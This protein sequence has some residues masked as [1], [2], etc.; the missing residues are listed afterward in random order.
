M[1]ALRTTLSQRL[2]RLIAMA[3]AMVLLTFGMVIV[4]SATSARADTDPPAGTPATVSDDALPTWQ[5]NGVVW[6][7]VTI[8]NTVYVAGE[9]SQARPPGVAVGGPGSVNVGNLIAYDITTGNLITSFNHTLN[10][11]A[12]VITKSPDNSRIYVGGDFTTVD[13]QPRGHIAAFDVAS[14]AL[15]PSFSPNLS[16]EVKA[17]TVSSSA[18]YAGGAFDYDDGVYRHHL[19]AMSITNG[20]RLPWAPVTDNY[21]PWT[22][23]MTPDQSKVVIG[24]QFVTLNGQ[25]VDGLAAVDPVTGSLVPWAASTKIPDAVHGAIMGLSTDGTNIYG[26]GYA[27]GSG[28]SFEGEFSLN[29]AD[30]SINW[31]NDCQGDTYNTFPMNGALYTVSHV[32]NCEMIGG[33]TQLSDWS[34]NQKHALAFSTTSSGNY[35]QGPD[36]YGWNYSAYQYAK[37]LTWYPNFLFGSYTAQKQSGWSITGNGNYLSIGGEFPSVNGKAQYGLVRFAVRSKAPNKMGPTAC[38][39]A[40]TPSALAM[41]GGSAR[42]SW[43][44]ATDPDNA[45]LTYN[46]YR[47]GTAAPIYTTTQSNQYWNCPQMG[48]RDTGLVGGKAYT[49]KITAS[50]SLGNTYTLPTTNSVTA[51]SGSPS[52]Y[53]QDVAKDGASDFWTLGEPSGSTIYDSAGFND[54]TAQS[55]VT[56]GA[57]GP[58]S[59]DST[60]ASTFGGS[61]N[62]FAATNST[63]ATTPALSV[64]AWIKTTTTSGGKI[65]GYGDSNTGTSGSYDRHVYMDNAGHIIW[66][67]YPGSVQTIQSKNTYNDGAWHYIVASMDPTAGIALYVDGKKVAANAGV[68]SAQSYSGY[69]KI[70]G[71]NLSGWTNQP[72]SNYFAGTIG[73]VAIYPAALSLAQVQTHYTDGGGSLPTPTI[74][75]DAYG[76]AVYNSNPALYWRL[77][78]TAGSTAADASANG[79]TGVYSGGVTLGQPGAL[80]SQGTAATF[81]GTDGTIG[82]SDPVSNPTVYSE[83]LWFNTT[84]TAGGKLIGFGDQQ[85]GNSGNYD[86]HVYM[87]PDGRL[88]FG[89]YPGSASIITSPNSYNDGAWHHMVAT[90][91]PDGMNLY[92][93]GQDVA[94]GPQTQAQPYTGYWRV[95]GDSSWAGNNYFAGT[96]DEVAVYS[97]ELSASTVQAHYVAGGGVVPNQPPVAAFTSSVNNLNASFDGSGSSDPDGT[98]ASYSW[99]FG[100]NSTAGTG[101]NPTHAYLSAGTYTV[102]L[103]VTDNQGATNSVSHT[104]TVTAPPVNQPPV[105]AFTSSVNNLNASFDG[106]GSSDPDGTVASYSWNFGDNSTAGT[107]VN[108]THAYT[109]AGTYTVTLTVTDNQGATNSVTH[110]ITVTAPVNQPPVA[111]F[112]SSVN[113]LT[114]SFD[115]SG[116]TDPDGT[117]AS[118]SWNFGDNSTAGTGVNPTHAYTS[119]G[120][121]T[122]TLTVTD[123]QGATNSVTHSITVTAPVNQ[124]P[125]AAFTSSVNNLTGSFDGSGSTDPDGT[126]ASYS[127]N[128]GD[129]STAGTGVNPTHAY[130]SAGTYTVTLTVTDNQG[131]TNSVSHAVT[132]AQAAPT[133]LAADDFGRTVASGWGSLDSGGAWSSSGSGLSVGGGVGRMKITQAGTGP[134]AYA[135]AVSTTQSDVRVQF[136]SDTMQSTGSLYV[137]V[138]GRRVA[139]VGDYRAKV[140]IRNDGQV[141]LAISRMSGTTE[142][143]TVPL[144]AISGLTASPGKTFDVRFDATGTTPTTLRAKVWADGTPEPSTWQVQAT[145]STAGLQTAGSPGLAAYL[146]GNATTVPVTVS[147]DGLRVYDATTINQQAMKAMAKG[148]KLQWMQTVTKENAKKLHAISKWNDS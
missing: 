123:N 108:P 142:V 47:S 140:W 94:S 1:T 26:S 148:V 51:S 138:L 107:G 130:T 89:V 145:D 39:A 147:F 69:W 90:Q 3:T 22:M 72:S 33:L 11:Q 115:G 15:V 58:I 37:I 56:R 111:A 126:V 55:D 124:P 116:S 128:F 66:G 7:Q 17:I 144:Q 62:G 9:F 10:A 81:N 103:T 49:Y 95:G 53:A 119:A 77:D 120:T 134:S 14:G 132:V 78:D 98:V 60:T 117:V 114:G 136:S 34:I 71:D 91:G 133:T 54:A 4:S 82:S 97:S 29:P 5:I 40:P 32:H 100:D 52:P 139:G 96:I 141:F 88:N 86:R 59:G 74:P 131:A 23:I 24:G 84:T 63:V 70:G 27:F 42:V 80:G 127:W 105:A 83:E 45:N 75:T 104:V 13:G 99:N 20:A 31:L 12:L 110:S 6:S 50:D 109:S 61:S 16:G 122:V 118:Y 146:S 73:D 43:Q 67:V 64:E 143:A 135:N 79:E 46:V 65:V 30:G 18:V 102:T 92:V 76:K 2:T 36:Q 112:T 8:G 38:Y 125:V 68:T 129:N 137:Y 48:Y 106:S 85:S 28:A 19:A 121:Y 93:D 41:A 25:E 35:D 87:T 44:A 113:N 57:A 21:V 101:V